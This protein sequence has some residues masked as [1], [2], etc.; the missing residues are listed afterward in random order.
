LLE[1]RA[2]GGNCSAI[3]E[4]YL[5]ISNANSKKLRESC[6][7]GGTGCVYREERYKAEY[8]SVSEHLSDPEVIKLVKALYANDLKFL[9]DSITDGDRVNAWF[10]DAFPLSVLELGLGARNLAVNAKQTLGSAALFAGIDGGIQYSATGE[11]KLSDLIAAG[12]FGALV[13]P[14]KAPVRQTTG[15]IVANAERVAANEVEQAVVRPSPRQS[16]LDVGVDLGP[17]VK[18]QVS[19]DS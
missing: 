11:V 10:W 9:D 4:K 18:P 15:E 2:A 3:V 13:A 1:C 16:E 19:Y 6:A 7:D 14:V 17:Q 8:L 5:A 12:V